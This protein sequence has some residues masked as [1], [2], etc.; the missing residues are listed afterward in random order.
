MV[1]CFMP[2]LSGGEFHPHVE[3]LSGGP[4]RA[5]DAGSHSTHAVVLGGGGR[6]RGGLGGGV[7]QLVPAPDPA[8]GAGRRPAHESS[9]VLRHPD[10]C[11]RS[12]CVPR[13]ATQA[14]LMSGGSSVA[15]HRALHYY[16][17]LSVCT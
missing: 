8:G 4:P 7:G 17:L 6:G 12:R 15:A 1:G 5:V 11:R 16:P 10:L 14:F 2:T 9:C 13:D 3:Q